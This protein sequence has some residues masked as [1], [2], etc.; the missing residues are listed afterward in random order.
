M[1]KNLIE[2]KEK[3]KKSTVIIGD[4][5]P[6]SVISDRTSRHKVRKHIGYTNKNYQPTRLN[7]HL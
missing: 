4:F 3:F 2:I 5:T 6:F 1:R 7:R